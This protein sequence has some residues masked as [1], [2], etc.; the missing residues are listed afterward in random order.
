[1]EKYNNMAF[2]SCDD[3]QTLALCIYGES[4]GEGI[5]GMLGVGSTVSNRAKMGRYTLKHVCLMPKQ[6][7]CFNP[8]DP[9]RAVLEELALGW[10]MYIETNQYLRQAYWIAKGLAERW[11]ISNVKN[12]THYHHVSIKPKWADK[13]EKVTKIGRHQFYFEKGWK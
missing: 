5:E 8:N 2:Q 10:D 11:L 9:N 7:S 3:V 4:R 12:A 6:Y 1:M 13:L